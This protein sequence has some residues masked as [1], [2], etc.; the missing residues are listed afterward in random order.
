MKSYRV[1][2]AA[3]VAA[4]AVAAGALSACAP[5]QAGAAAIV[6]DDRISSSELDAAVRSIHEDAAANGLDATDEQRATPPL[7]GP[8]EVLANIAGSRQII[9]FGRQKGIDVTEREIDDMLLGVETQAKQQGMTINQV[10]LLSGIPLS[11]GRT[12]IRAVLVRRKLESRIAG[13]EADPQMV[14]EKLGKEVDTTV[15]I[16][17]SPRYGKFDPER[18]TFIVDD[19]FGA[20][21]S[22]PAASPEDIPQAG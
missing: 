8:R 16:K 1:R 19:R 10:L 13:A 3:A 5:V 9:E 21:Q 18:Q 11:E 14:A 15:P 12:I 17:F 6:G 4:A 22:A 2:V 20:V 7:P